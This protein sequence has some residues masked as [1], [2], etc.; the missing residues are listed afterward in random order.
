[1]FNVGKFKCCLHTT[2]LAQEFIYLNKVDST[3]TYLKNW[4]KERLCHGTLCL[5]DQQSAGRGQ[6]KRTWISEPFSNLTFTISFQPTHNLSPHV[7]NLACAAA[8]ADTA[9]HYTGLKASVKWPNDVI[10]NGNGKKLAGLLS[11][12]IYSGTHC[13][14]VLIGIGLNVNQ[15]SF[16]KGLSEKATSLAQLD[17]NTG[18]EFDRE[19]VLAWLLS[20]IEYYYQLYCKN[21]LK[22]LKKIN[23]QIIGYGEWR[24]VNTL[25]TDKEPERCKI[26]GINEQGYLLAL[27]SSH[28]IRTFTYEQIRILQPDYHGSRYHRASS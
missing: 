5:A 23:R 1:M 22:L 4:S 27:N 15:I 18:E 14:Q 17:T 13:D 12:S 25:N 20:R 8:I 3:N 24:Y 19:T 11:E 16:D 10:C 28:E 9:K 7:L 6:Y 2:W 26:L 21:P